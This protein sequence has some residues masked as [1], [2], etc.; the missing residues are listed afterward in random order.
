[1]TCFA[2]VPLPNVV[3]SGANKELSRPTS[4]RQIAPSLPKVDVGSFC[5]GDR[6]RSRMDYYAI[7]LGCTVI[8]VVWPRN[9]YERS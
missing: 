2:V 4:E 7:G 5:P 1:M 6:L 8:I 3:R 9:G